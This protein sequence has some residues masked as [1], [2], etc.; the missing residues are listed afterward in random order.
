MHARFG[1][2]LHL[3]IHAPEQVLDVRVPPLLPQPLVENAVRHGR[4]ERE[5]TGRITVTAHRS[6]THL[7]LIVHDDGVGIELGRGLFGEGS[8]LSITARRLELMFGAAAQIRVGNVN[9]GGFAV[10]VHVPSV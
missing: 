7:E 8:G 9:A 10:T 5:G 4:L 2:R 6:A 3:S 1:A